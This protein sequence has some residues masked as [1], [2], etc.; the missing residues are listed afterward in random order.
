MNNTDTISFLRNVLDEE[1]L[2]KLNSA[3]QL[4]GLDNRIL[5][6]RSFFNQ[7]KIFNKI[8]VIIDPSWVCSEII[9]KGKDYEF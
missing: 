2:I 1:D 4:K 3:N 5:S 9:I 7:P 6:L 8:K